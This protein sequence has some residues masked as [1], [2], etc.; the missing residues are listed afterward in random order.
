MVK[1]FNGLGMG[2]GN[3]SVLS[4]AESRSISAENLTGA[5]GMS[6]TAEDGTGAACASELGQGEDNQFVPE[7]SGGTEKRGCD[8]YSRK[9]L[10]LFGEES[11][12]IVA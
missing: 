9:T 10:K 6:G 5:K 8:A 12:L 7:K 3:L 2:L 4:D 11:I 1:A